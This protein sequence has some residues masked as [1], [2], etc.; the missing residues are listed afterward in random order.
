[1]NVLLSSKNK[2]KEKATREILEEIY[3]EKATVLLFDSESGVS[4]TPTSDEE[5]IKGAINRIEYAEKHSDMLAD[6]V[7]GLEGIIVEN[8]F[9]TFLCGWAVI[10]DS[11]GKFGFGCSSKVR[12]P[13]ELVSSL[14]ENTNLSDK[15]SVL[16]P[17]DAG[18]LPEIGTNG[19]LTNGLYTRVDEFKDAIKC[20][21]GNLKMSQ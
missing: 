3:N 10:K 18:L 20:A 21:I 14:G 2:A 4:N 6:L 12:L 11:N 1:M 8:S 5:G 19:V 17:D 13:D 9:G 15:V 7:I 16:Y